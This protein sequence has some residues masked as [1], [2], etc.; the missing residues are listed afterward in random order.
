[1]R[2]RYEIYDGIPLISKWLTVVNDGQHPIRLNSFVSENLAVIEPEV[3]VDAPDQWER[4]NLHIESDYAFHGMTPKTANRTTYW[5]TDS[6]FTSQVN[7]DLKTPCLLESRPPLGPDLALRPGELFDT[8]RTFELV[9][10]SYDRERKGLA[11]R[12][13]YRT[14]APWVTEN[15]IFLHLTS[16]DPKV[17]KEA[18]DQCVEVGFEMIIL[19]FG[20]GLNMESDDPAYIAQMKQLVDYAHS[21]GI[22]LGG[23]S[24]LASRRIS[25]Q[26]DVVNPKTGKTGGA[27]FGD[28]PCLQSAWG[29]D[30]FRRLRN[31][32][33]KALTFLNTTDRI[34]VM[35]APRCNT[36]VTR[37]WMTLSGNS[38]RRSR[39]SMPGAAD[40]TFISM[41]PTGTSS[42]VR[43]RPASD[44]VR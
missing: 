25:D 29:I 15:P 12:R 13:M 32:L 2:V 10:D 38:G 14:I 42:L 6:L 40:E 23:Y 5:V 36:R 33:D 24:L 18:V 3:A 17:V 28:S 16:T 43:T 31:F 8:F 26:D 9:Y 21:K 35:F 7:Y 44:I 30:Y 19:S 41:S 37:D 11:L 4:P 1:V 22:E 20:S 34:R 39:I 27:I